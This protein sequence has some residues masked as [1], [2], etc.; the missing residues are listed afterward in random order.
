MTVLDVLQPKT[1]R[2]C[3]RAWNRP[4]RLT[5]VRYRRPAWYHSGMNG[6][7][8]PRRCYRDDL[9]SRMVTA[10]LLGLPGPVPR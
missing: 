7:E 9:G 2:R 10:R 1:H 4:S 6:I 5:R 8:L 3:G